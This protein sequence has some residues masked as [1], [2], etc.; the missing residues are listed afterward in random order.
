MK[1]NLGCG[2]VQPTGWINVDASNRAWLASRLPWLDR[3]LVICRVMAPTEFNGSTVYANLLRRFPWGDNAVDSIYMGEILEHFTP[4]AGE[5]V[6]R[7]CY[8]VLKPSGILRIRVPDHARFWKNYIEEYEAAKKQPRAQ[9]SMAHTRW[10][11]MYFDNLCNRRP[12]LWQSMGHYHKWMYDEISLTL[13]VESVGFLHVER[14][15]LHQSAISRIEEVE[16]RD[17]LI[18]EATRP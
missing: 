12:H 15:A 5:H 4:I 2:P 3:F 10:T 9:W 8:R 1:M 11:E 7:E 17:D 18:I 16:K 13:L 6:L 14:R